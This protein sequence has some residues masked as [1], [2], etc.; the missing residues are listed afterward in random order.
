[1]IRL[2]DSVL[3]HELFKILHHIARQSSFPPLS[4]SSLDGSR[5]RLY[6]ERPFL[7]AILRHPPW[8]DSD[9]VSPHAPSPQVATRSQSGSFPSRQA[10]VL[11]TTSCLLS[12]CDIGPFLLNQEG[13]PCRFSFRRRKSPRLLK[14]ILAAAGPAFCPEHLLLRS[15]RPSILASPQIS[16][17]GT[18]TFTSSCQSS[19][20]TYIL[21]TNRNSSSRII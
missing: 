17:W 20:F 2:P 5:Q 11:V 16:N 8:P 14:R 12:L 6:L 7:P 21:D 13:N 18:S 1:M 4:A 10:H 3:L 9:G 15:R 19:H